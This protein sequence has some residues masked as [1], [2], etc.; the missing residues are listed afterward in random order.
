MACASARADAPPTLKADVV[1]YGGTPAGLAAAIQAARMGHSAVVI[2]P[3]R[4]IGGMMTGGLGASDKGVTWTVGGLAREFYERLY[5]YYEAKDAWKHETRDEFLPRHGQTHTKA[6]LCQWYFEPHVATKTFQA[7][8]AE[9]GVKVLVNERLDRQRGMSKA[10]HPSGATQVQAITLE[11]GRRVEGTY[12]IDA[13]YE[14][15]LMAAVGVSYIVGRESND[16]YGETVN[17]IQYEKSITVAGLSPYVVDGDS[18]SGL[19]PRIDAASPGPIGSGDKRTQ[20]YNFRLCLTDVPE[21]RVTITKPAGYNALEYELTLRHLQKRPD[22]K[23]GSHFYSLTPLPNRKTDSNN[24]PIFSTDYIG[25]NHA[26]PEASYAERDKLLAQHRTYVQGLLWFLAN[27]PRVPQD[28]R[29]ACG[30]WGLCKDEFADNEH[31][32]TQLYVREARRMIGEHVMNEHNYPHKYKDD[33]GKKAVTPAAQPVEDPV[34]VGSY[35]LDSHKVSM[36]V[37]EAGKLVLEGHLFKGV[38][39]YGI[40]YRSLLP[41]RTECANLLVPVCMSASHVAYT[42]IRMEPVY[43]ELGQAAGA[44]ACLAM[45]LKTTPHDLPYATLQKRLLADRAVLDTTEP[46]KPR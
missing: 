16:I 38:M 35:A 32:P 2:E 46:K 36:F 22:F 6:M 33:A 7:M 4:W 28:V 3:S 9:A 42:S 19:L 21:N 17:G 40:S 29:T 10:V 44:A 1:V 26:W 25:G 27:D 5:R 13:T 23:P 12:F 30:R 14:G 18:Q 34:A 45:D 39:P 43:M 31:W 8:L 15:D 20:A 24:R 41:K 37:N 11:N